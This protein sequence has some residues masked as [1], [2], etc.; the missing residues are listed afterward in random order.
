MADPA[1]TDFDWSDWLEKLLSNPAGLPGY[2]VLKEGGDTIVFAA[3]LGPS[4]PVAVKHSRRSGLA[5]RLARLVRPS[6]EA[7]EFQMAR[8]LTERGVA[9]PRPIAWWGRSGSVCHALLVTH[10]VEYLRDLDQVVMVEVP[11]RGGS[12]RAELKRRIARTLGRTLADFHRAG[13]THRDL[14]ASNILVQ[15]LPEHGANPAIWLVDLKGVSYS[16]S[17]STCREQRALIR[18]AASLLEHRTLTRT[19]YARFLTHYVGNPGGE[20]RAWRA[21]FADIARQAADYNRRAAKR[22]LGKIDGY[23]GA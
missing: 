4:T 6:A 20:S 16:P 8:V 22:K 9:T 7:Q 18:L 19:D 21:L 12:E 15:L 2:C 3:R 14:K 1:L 11:R 5:A 10:R 13:F 17:R 23:A